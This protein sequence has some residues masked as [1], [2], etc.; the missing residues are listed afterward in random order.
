[1]P[2]RGAPPP[3]FRLAGRTPPIE[4]PFIIGQHAEGPGFADRIDEVA[5]FAAALQDPTSRLVVYGDRRLGKSSALLAAADRVRA[6]GVPVAYVDL[7]KVSSPVAAAQRVLAAVQREVGASAED[8]A[9]QVATHL[10][11]AVTVSMTANPGGATTFALKLD[12]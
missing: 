6:E 12:P 4:N 10:R 1:M 2:R 9:K 7:G 5:R 3:S 8:L 11:G